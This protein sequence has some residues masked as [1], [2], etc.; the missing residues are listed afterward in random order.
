MLNLVVH[1]VTARPYKVAHYAEKQ[2]LKNL[3]LRRRNS[4]ETTGSNGQITCT[5]YEV[6]ESR[7][8]TILRN[9]Q[10]MSKI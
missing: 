5:A 4:I 3:T 6:G 1:T 8:L 9:S 10:A 7:E 2:K